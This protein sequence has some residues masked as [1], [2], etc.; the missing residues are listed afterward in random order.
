MNGEYILRRTVKLLAYR[1]ESAVNRLDANQHKNK[2][3]EPTLCKNIHWVINLDIHVVADRR[4][5][6]SLGRDDSAIFRLDLVRR[7]A[8]LRKATRDH[9]AVAIDIVLIGVLSLVLE[10]DSH[11]C[12]TTKR[13]SVLDQAFCVYTN[14]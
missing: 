4:E 6:I 2:I 13:C 8:F 5:L 12:R 1:A 3:L 9:N 7:R 11:L 10:D 14:A